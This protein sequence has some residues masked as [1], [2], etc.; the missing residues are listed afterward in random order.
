MPLFISLIDY[1][2]FTVNFKLHRNSLHF[3]RDGSKAASNIDRK[4]E[5]RNW[6]HWSNSWGDIEMK[7]D[8]TLILKDFFKKINRKR[9]IY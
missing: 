9:M 8:S 5:R 4:K 3:S 7:Y 1:V 2:H 6:G